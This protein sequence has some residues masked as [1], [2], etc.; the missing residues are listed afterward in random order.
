LDETFIDSREKKKELKR[1]I[2][3]GSKV[4]F[5]TALDFCRNKLMLSLYEK[6]K[7]KAFDLADELPNALIINGEWTIIVR[8]YWK[9]KIW[10]PWDAFVL[11][12]GIPETQ[13][14]CL[15]GGQSP[16][17]LRRQSL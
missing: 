10:R 15:L 5:K 14:L 7:E 6:N 16:R 4:G 3:G 12:T 17:M 9:R 8:Y 11:V 1:M 13:I 2:L